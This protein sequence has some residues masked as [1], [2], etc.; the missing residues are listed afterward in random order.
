MYGYIYK[1]T[2]LVNGTIYIGQRKGLFDKTYFGSGTLIKRAVC[3]YNLHNF[4][5]KVLCFKK[6]RILLNQAE[7]HF[8][9]VYRNKGM[10]YNIADGGDGGNLGKN[11]CLKIGRA[12]KKNWKNPEYRKKVIEARKDCNAGKKHPL[13]GKPAVNRGVPHTNKTKHK[14]SIS[15]R[16]RAN[17]PEGKLH[18]KSLN[19]GKILS[20]EH[21]NKISKSCK[22]KTANY[23]YVYYTPSGQFK[24][25]TGAAKGSN[26]SPD[27]I[28]QM[29][30]Y[31]TDKVIT[32]HSL[33][34][35]K[36]IG[37]TDI[38]KTYKELGWYT[39]LVGG[40]IL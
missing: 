17:T 27:I 21:K 10:V 8:I 29:C 4:S 30:I 13:Y 2:N 40:V 3:K 35:G 39:V 16:N 19:K 12:T 25:A 34:R 26:T 7:K 1:T 15:A 36:L 37:T 20:K 5:V 11:A 32:K 14:M 33:C 18:M 22:G 6:T 24:T 38:G 23:T 28:R 31:N 9:S